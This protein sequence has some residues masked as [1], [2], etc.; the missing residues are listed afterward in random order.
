MEDAFEYHGQDNCL[1]FI[2]LNRATAHLGIPKH[3][4]GTIA[5]YKGKFVHVLGS[6]RVNVSEI[7]TLPA[8]LAQ[9]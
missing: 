2:G 9:E 6:D 8:T 3:L 5:I 7:N 1:V 4:N